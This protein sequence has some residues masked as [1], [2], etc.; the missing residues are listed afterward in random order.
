[1]SE[2]HADL[3]RLLDDPGTAAYSRIKYLRA[4]GAEKQIAEFLQGLFAAAAEARYDGDL[5]G[6]DAFMER[7]EDAALDMQYRTTIEPLPYRWRR[8]DYARIRRG[9][10]SIVAMPPVMAAAPG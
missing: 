3:K 6:L 7:W 10:G 9:C 8:E 4:F 1:M 2:S 5:G